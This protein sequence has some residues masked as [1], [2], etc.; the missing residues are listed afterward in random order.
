[1]TPRPAWPTT[2]SVCSRSL[3]CWTG[4]PTRAGLRV[5]RYRFGA[6][7]VLRVAAVLV[8]ATTLAAIARF[9]AG[10]DPKLHQRIG[11]A[12][13]GALPRTCTLGHL[14]GDALDAAVGAWLQ[15]QHADPLALR[16][17][18]RPTLVR[19][20]A[21]RSRSTGRPCAARATAAS[22]PCTCSPPACKAPAPSSPSARSTP[23]ATRSPRS[24]RCWNGSTWQQRQRIP[25]FN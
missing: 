12:W 22:G 9:A 17:P 5:R 1:M 23:G 16:R 3:G 7:L 21:A 11:L 25:A 24:G 13:P 14:D 19:A 18:A 6:L 20:N 15:Q 4:S 2:W 8:D 10:L